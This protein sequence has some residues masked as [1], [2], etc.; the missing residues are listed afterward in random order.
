MKS[1]ILTN[2]NSPRTLVD[3]DAETIGDFLSSQ[4]ISTDDSA[5]VLNGAVA[6]LSTPINDGD[7]LTVSRSA[8][9]A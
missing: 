5:F 6:S 9:G 7:R 1:I 4:G 2:N 3:T 8:K